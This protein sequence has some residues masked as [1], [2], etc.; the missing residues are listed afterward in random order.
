MAIRRDS[1]ARAVR[2]R[3][4]RPGN[5][6]SAVRP[7]CQDLLGTRSKLAAD[8]AFTVLGNYDSVPEPG[9]LIMLGTGV[10]GVAGA[11]RRKLS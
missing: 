7:D 6:E 4:G 11:I 9:T 10:L 8:M 2:S 5:V 1:R 3:M